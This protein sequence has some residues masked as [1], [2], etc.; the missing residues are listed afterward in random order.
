[1]KNILVQGAGGFIGGWLVKDLLS[2]GHKVIGVDIKPIDKWWQVHGTAVNLPGVDLR[3]QAQ[4][5]E[6]FKLFAPYDEV[7]ALSC[8]MGGILFITEFKLECIKSVAIMTNTLEACHQFGADKIFYSSSACAYNT[9]LQQSPEVIALK[10]SDAYPAM[11]E[12]G[13]GWEKLFSERLCRHYHEDA[14]LD[15]RVFRFHNVMGPCFD[16]ETEI[17]T[18]NGWKLFSDL[19]EG[20]DLVAT[21][22]PES[23]TLEYQL[24]VAYQAH[25]YSGDMYKVES[26]SVDQLVTEDHS[27][28]QSVPKDSYCNG[29]VTR[30][31]T[32]FR[33]T[34]ASELKWDRARMRFTSRFQWNDGDDFDGKIVLPA[35]HMTDGRS[36]HSEKIL[37]IYDWF[38]FAGWFISEGSSFITPSNYTVNISQNKVGQGPIVDVLN[39]MGFKAYCN[40]RNVIVSN[41]QLYEAC[42]Q[43]GKHCENKTI[44]RW[45]L[46]AN[47]EL[48]GVLFDSLMAG[49]GDADGGKYSTT[50]PQLKDDFM[51]VAL[52]M[53]KGAWA[54]VEK[55]V[56]PKH[57]DIWRIHLTDKE[58][59]VTK[60]SHRNIENYEGMVYDVTVKEHHI[61]L[62][63]RNNKPVWSGNCGSWNDGTEKAPAAICRK[64]A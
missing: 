32:E 19:K 11:P 21:L 22:N 15:T 48:L 35:A 30:G 9:D 39:R 10:E 59:S 50:S 46:S 7:Y 31:N 62:V 5:R 52:K 24:P 6:S 41:K 54:N 53:G 44:P 56:N 8:A 45:M 38:E 3:E 26:S 18:K 40:G 49:D 2:K 63:R 14:G 23:N 37:D 57:K 36:L 43:F 13:Y 27:L 4:C 60:R 16:S 33:L 58:S 17:L 12:D 47:K 51:E 55:R 28:Y 42:K 61:L 64:V 25:W 20:E 1:M 29:E 34:K